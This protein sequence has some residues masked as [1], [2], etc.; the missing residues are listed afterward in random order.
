MVT[1]LRLAQ[2]DVSGLRALSARRRM[3]ANPYGRLAPAVIR[4]PR[5]GPVGRQPIDG[6]NLA[7]SAFGDVPP[8]AANTSQS[9]SSLGSIGLFA[10]PTVDCGRIRDVPRTLKKQRPGVSPAPS[11]CA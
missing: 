4:G 10:S 3:T 2:P 11:F 6:P 8:L 9:L 7:P 1:P 5:Q